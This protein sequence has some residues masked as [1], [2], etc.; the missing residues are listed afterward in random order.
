M[1]LKQKLGEISNEIA[2]VDG[3]DNGD[4]DADDDDVVTLPLSNYKSECYERKMK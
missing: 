1:Q 3:S 2:T 4:D